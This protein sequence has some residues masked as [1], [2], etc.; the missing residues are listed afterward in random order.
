[1]VVKYPTFLKP[2]EA[3]LSDCMTEFI[4]SRKPL[5][6]LTENQLSTPSRSSRI[7]LAATLI[8]GTLECVIQGSA[9]SSSAA[10]SSRVSYE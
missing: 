3:L 6:V 1:M 8:R 9:R 4:S 10:A 7:V 5:V 2:L